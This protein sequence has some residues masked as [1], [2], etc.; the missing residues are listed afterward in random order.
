MTQSNAE[1]PE[2]LGKRG[3]AMW[4]TLHTRA[5]LN[6]LAE[7]VALELCRALDLADRLA[8]VIEAEGTMTRGSMGQPRVH[9][10]V[11]ELRATQLA[12]A[13]L[14][15]LLTTPPKATQKGPQTPEQRHRAEHA[16]KAANARWGMSG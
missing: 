12:V 8:E 7:E 4:T 2:G 9:P 5:R 6:P 16:R 1:V 15:A 11:A 14:T 3:T 13:R 10:A